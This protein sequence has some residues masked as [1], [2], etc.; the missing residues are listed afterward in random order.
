MNQNIYYIESK[1]CYD[2]N[3]IKFGV[4]FLELFNYYEFDLMSGEYNLY[5]DKN[6]YYIFEE[7]NKKIILNDSKTQI[8]AIII[9]FIFVMLCFTL[10]IFKEYHRNKKIESFNHYFEI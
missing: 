2:S 7:E 9:L 1:P 3:K 4:K 6:K 5:L 8:N 10:V